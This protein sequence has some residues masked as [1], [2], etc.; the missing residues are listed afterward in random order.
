MDK[1]TCLGSFL[2]FSCADNCLFY[3]WYICS[4][5]VYLMKA[6]IHSSD[7]VPFAIAAAFFYVVDRIFRLVWGLKPEKVK[8]VFYRDASNFVLQVKFPKNA[9]A[10]K[11][12]VRSYLQI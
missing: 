1:K 10:A 4:V 11:L 2:L 5:V 3:R 8:G 9:I 12:G 6:C 7:V